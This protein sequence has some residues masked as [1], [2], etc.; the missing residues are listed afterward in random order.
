VGTGVSEYKLGVYPPALSWNTRFFL[1]LL[2]IMASSPYYEPSIA[3]ASFLASWRKKLSTQLRQTSS[4]YSIPDDD[5]PFEYDDEPLHKEAEKVF[6]DADGQV[7]EDNNWAPNS[8]SVALSEF[9]NL[10]QQLPEVSMALAGTMI[11]Q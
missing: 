6:D 1:Q 2:V 10:E 4:I 5:C 3:P 7:A 11:R 9:D 8:P